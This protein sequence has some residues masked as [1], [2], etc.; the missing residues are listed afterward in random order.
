[1]H[2][3]KERDDGIVVRG[4]RLVST[5]AAFSSVTYV[6]QYI[7]ITGLAA[8]EEDFALAFFVPFNAPGIKFIERHSYEHLVRKIGHP[9][10]IH[11]PAASTSL[12]SA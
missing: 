4:A 6:S 5:G 9:S 3:V 12:I 7:P 2:V 10:T 1:M 11:S 8:N